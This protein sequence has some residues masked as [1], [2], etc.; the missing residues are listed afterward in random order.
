MTL[1]RSLQETQSRTKHLGMG[2]HQWL[3]Q[4]KG[5][6]GK[7]WI[8]LFCW[9]ENPN[10]LPWGISSWRIAEIEMALRYSHREFISSLSFWLLRLLMNSKSC[11]NAQSLQEWFELSQ[12]RNENDRAFPRF[13]IWAQF[14]SKL[15][16]TVPTMNFTRDIVVWSTLSP[17]S[18]CSEDIRKTHACLSFNSLELFV[19]FFSTA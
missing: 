1:L 18:Q 16:E 4:W 14:S 19:L 5:I 17:Q 10:T 2:S 8:R 6:T 13:S 11:Q 7:I 3:I 9:E 15:S 12:S